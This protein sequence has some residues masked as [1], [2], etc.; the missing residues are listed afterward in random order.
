MAKLLF[1]TQ[2]VDKDDDILGAYHRWTEELSKKIGVVNVICLYKGRSELPDNVG[3][4]SLGKE[5]NYLGIFCKLKYIFNF[6]RY[7]WLLRKDYDA[8]LVHMNP[9]YVVL[10]GLFWKVTGKKIFLWYNHPMG[11]LNAKI[12][13]ALADKVFCTSFQAFSAKYKK[14][15]LMPAGIDTDLFRPMPEIEKK[16]NRILYLGR[17]SPIKNIDILIKAAKILNEKG[18]DFELLIIGSPASE[19]DKIYEEE[20]KNIAKSLIESGKI[21]FK[22]SVPYCKT[23]EIYNSCGVFINLTPSGSLDKTTLEAMACE[24]LFLV[25]NRVFKSLLSDKLRGLCLFREND[26]Q[27]LAVKIERLLTPDVTNKERIGEESRQVIADNHSLNKLIG[28]LCQQL[29]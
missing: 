20:L 19:S 5:N 22:P 28:L 10:G 2:K 16:Q 26:S 12:G 17:I 15:E 9:I 4:Y 14:T 13:I 23:P 7:I 18:I 29:T 8:I 25:S 3:V 24:S 21:I 11:N 6:Y 27:D 1:I